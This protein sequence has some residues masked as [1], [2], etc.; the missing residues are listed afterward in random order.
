MKQQVIYDKAKP[1]SISVSDTKLEQIL[2]RV[3]NFRFPT[4]VASGGWEHGVS[5][6]Y[7][8]QLVD[9]W[10]SKYDWRRFEQDLNR[11]PQFQAHIDGVMIHYYHV[12]GAGDNPM[13]LLLTHGWPGSVIEYIYMIDRLTNPV[14]HGGR[15]EDAFSV[16]IPSLPGYGWSEK[17]EAWVGPV[18]TS[19]LLNKLMT[20]V[21]GYSQYGSHAGDLG[22]LM[23]VQLAS[24]H[25]KNLLGAHFLNIA[26]PPVPEDER[27]EEEKQ[28]LAD[29]AAFTQAEMS[30]F[31]HHMLKPSTMMFVLEDNPVG[32]AAWWIEKIWAWS[33]R[34]DD[35]NTAFSKDRVLDMVMTYLVTDTMGSA[36][37][38]Y[39]AIPIE[40]QWQSYPTTRIDVPIAIANF[41]KDYLLAHPP[42]SIAER[43][44]NVVQWSVFEHGGHYAG[45]EQPVPLADDIRK[46]FRALRN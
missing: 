21:L 25:A 36:M 20:E 11:H 3:K 39:G 43:G 34:G 12:Q 22:G 6:N 42:R 30:Y 33:D 26:A 9:Y 38:Y 16:V 14:A 28:W 27:S 1:F 44:F 23:Q 35:F 29:S 5:H 40:T 41:P 10:I 17:P 2:E 8:R 46:F 13:P 7:M 37:N 32:A 19:D 31:P 18:T 24:R 15:I 4:Q 45:L